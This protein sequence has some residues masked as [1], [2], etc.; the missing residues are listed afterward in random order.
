MRTEED[1]ETPN[2]DEADLRPDDLLA[3]Q[4]EVRQAIEGLYRDVS[5]RKRLVAVAALI[6]RGKPHLKRQ[7]QPE[8]LFQEA[9]ERIGIGLRAWP[10]N[11][12]DFAGL[13]VGVMRSWASSLEKTKSRE[14]DMVVMEHELASSQNDDEGPNLEETAADARTPSEHLAGC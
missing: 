14:D 5:T 8:D 1:D 10:K 6:L 9:L 3:N 11:R 2:D 13:V 4:A 7:Y 12:V